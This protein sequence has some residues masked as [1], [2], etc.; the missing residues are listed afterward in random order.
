M[1]WNNLG[2][3]EWEQERSHGGAS[4]E[5]AAH[6][7]E[8]ALRLQREIGDTRGVA[9]ALNNLGVLAHTQGELTAARCHYEEAL[10]LLVERRDALGVAQ[11]LSNLGEVAEAEGEQP[12]AYR[13]MIAAEALFEEIGSPLRDYA[14]DLRRRIGSRLEADELA[15]RP[16]R[17]NLSGSDLDDLVRWALDRAGFSNSSVGGSDRTGGG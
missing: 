3:V 7:F 15:A 4:R 12:H 14:A 13:L 1:A 16:P 10:R 2:R 6:H 9:W 5:L 17:G 8:E 11:A